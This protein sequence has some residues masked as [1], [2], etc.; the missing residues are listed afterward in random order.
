MNLKKLLENVDIIEIRG[1]NDIEIENIKYN[2]KDVEMGDIFVAIKGSHFDGHNFIEDAIKKGACAVV[3]Q[4]NKTY[5]NITNIVVSES[6]KALAQLSDRFY[7]SPS[8]SLKLIG[9]TGTNGKTTTSYLIKSII[10]TSGEKVGLLGTISYRIENECIDASLTTPESLEMHSFFNKI[11]K[12]KAKYA[13]LEVSSH[14]LKQNRTYGLKFHS[15]VFTNI[16]R[17]HLDYHQNMEDYINSKLM[18]FAQLDDKGS[19]AIINTDDVVSERIIKNVKRNYFNYSITKKSDIYPINYE[20]NFNGI[21]LTANTPKGEININSKLIGSFNIYNIL[22]AIGVGIGLDIDSDAIKRGIELI[23]NVPGR[24]EKL[25][26]RQKYNI[27]IDY[28]HTP[29]SLFNIISTMK[30]I[31]KGRVIAVFGCGGDRDKGKRPIMGRIAEENADITIITSDN[32]RTE[33][34]NQII[35][36]IVQGIKKKENIIQIPDRKKAIFKALSIAE[37]SDSVLI[38]GKGHETYQIIGNKKIHFNDKEVVTEFFK[39]ERN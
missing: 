15:A 4:N 26:L 13:V 21:R 31:T 19:F 14:S 22:A 2:S 32:P 10:E 3:H 12:L 11:N 8:K 29:D 39:K 17:D 30:R 16:S 5:S 27:I 37:E 28:S 24:A 35:S 1:N 25:E 38:L 18:L 20:I 9:I 33:D 6:R 7:N 36:D 23:E 34:P